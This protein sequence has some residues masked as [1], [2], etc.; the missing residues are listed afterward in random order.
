MFRTQ[1]LLIVDDDDAINRV[2]ER[3]ARDHGWSSATAR[4][5]EEALEQVTSQL[6]ANPLIAT[7]GTAVTG[8]TLEGYLTSALYTLPQGRR[9]SLD[10]IARALA[11]AP[12]S[13]V[14]VNTRGQTIVSVAV[15][16]QRFR[17]VKGALLLSTQGGDIDAVMKLGMNHPIGPLALADLIGLDTCLAIMDVLYHELRDS[18]YRACPLLVQMVDAGQLGRKTAKGFYGYES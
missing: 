3:L 14:R 4:S 17:A 12:A 16:V 10:K 18:K 6:T 15:P 5:G 9:D 7:D 13:V 11:G 2:F 1:N 8:T